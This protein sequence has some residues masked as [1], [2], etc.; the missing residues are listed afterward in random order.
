MIKTEEYSSKNMSS[1]CLRLPK[2]LKDK[3]D[4]ISKKEK[5]STNNQ[6][7]IVLEKFLEENTL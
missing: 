1:F 2:D 5:R 7:L 3:L 6:I 4:N